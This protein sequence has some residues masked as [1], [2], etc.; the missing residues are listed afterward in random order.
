MRILVVD[1]DEDVLDTLSHMLGEH[2]V[3]AALNG[4]DAFRIYCEHLSQGKTFDFVLLG[5]ELP[6]MNGIALRRAIWDKNHDQ[7]L[8]W[9]TGY[10]VLQRPHDKDQLLAFVK[11]N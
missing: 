5:L 11:C 9:T 8:G 1:D 7:R 3:T 10:P 6:G 4:A 2:E